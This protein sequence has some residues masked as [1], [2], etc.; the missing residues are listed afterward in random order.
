MNSR[1]ILLYIVCVTILSCGKDCDQE[2]FFIDLE[3]EHNIT[4]ECIQKG[5]KIEISL[6]YP[7]TLRA[8]SGSVFTVFDTIFTPN[9][10]IIDSRTEEEI[11]LVDIKNYQFVTSISLHKLSDTIDL[12]DEQPRALDDFSVDIITGNEAL[13]SFEPGNYFSYE[14]DRSNSISNL[15]LSITT[16]DTGSYYL[17]MIHGNAGIFE[18]AI[19]IDECDDLIL[20]SYNNAGVINENVL[21][22]AV[23]SNAL[24]AERIMELVNTRSM[25]FFKV[26]DDLG[27]GCL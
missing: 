6:T 1:F 19:T 20:A 17:S 11:N 12:F 22:Q 24:G 15:E 3:P 14:P 21:F 16:L 2:F 4:S 18:N 10:T 7:D 8:F 5:D 25:F 27:Q 23:D 26:V 13:N 9:D